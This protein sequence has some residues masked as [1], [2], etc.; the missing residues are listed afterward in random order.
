MLHS[1]IYS[2]NQDAKYE[3]WRS[4]AL[5]ATSRSR[6]LPRNLESLRVVQEETLS[7]SEARMLRM[8]GKKHFDSLKCQYQSRN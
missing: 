5:Y 6:G 3:L 7:L 8:E 1:H 2:Y 4:E